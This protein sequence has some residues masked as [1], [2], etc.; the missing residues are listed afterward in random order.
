MDSEKH[1][2]RLRE[3]LEQIAEATTG[4]NRW[5]TGVELGCDPD[6]AACIW[7]YNAHGGPEHFRA[8]QQQTAQTE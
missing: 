5:V 6:N 3:N 1:A 2:Q 7:H 8:R 4:F